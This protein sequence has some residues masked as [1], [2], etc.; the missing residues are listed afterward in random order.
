MVKRGKGG[1]KIGVGAEPKENSGLDR[2]L[3]VSGLFVTGQGPIFFETIRFDLVE[4]NNRV[5]IRKT[6]AANAE[7]AKPQSGPVGPIDVELLSS[8]QP[9]TL[10][11]CFLC[12]DQRPDQCIVTRNGAELSAFVGNPAVQ[13]SDP[14]SKFVGREAQAFSAVI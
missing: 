7:N 3:V 6:P 9:R 2:E 11:G 4:I 12:R 14:Y 1:Y 10:G 8:S 5:G 13:L